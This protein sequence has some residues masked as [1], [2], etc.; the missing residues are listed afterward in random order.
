MHRI[1]NIDPILYEKIMA[2]EVE[3]YSDMN[4][5]IGELIEVKKLVVSGTT[6]REAREAFAKI[7][8]RNGPDK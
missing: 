7:R 8:W 3:I 5:V 1:K 2:L 6:K 4:E